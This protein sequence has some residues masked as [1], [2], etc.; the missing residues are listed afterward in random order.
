MLRFR[1]DFELKF[2]THAGLSQ[3]CRRFYSTRMIIDAHDSPACGIMLQVCHLQ[4]ASRRLRQARG[5]RNWRIHSRLTRDAQC[6]QLSPTDKAQVE[7][8]SLQG[9]TT[10]LIHKLKRM[11]KSNVF[12]SVSKC[13]EIRILV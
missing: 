10:N 12:G 9:N 4:C 11:F 8:E 1:Y 5:F 7:R 6:T 13:L 3:Q 2:P